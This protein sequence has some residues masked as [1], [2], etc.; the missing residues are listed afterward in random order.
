MY[1]QKDERNTKIELEIEELLVLELN[2]TWEE[3]MFDL[4]FNDCLWNKFRCNF[5]CFWRKLSHINI[6]THLN[7]LPFTQKRIF[8]QRLR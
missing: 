5:F 1:K 7:Y 6:L 3:N 4:S 2:I 8:S